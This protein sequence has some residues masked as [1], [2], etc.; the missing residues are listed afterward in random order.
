MRINNNLMAMNTHRQ[1][2]LGNANGAKSMEKL[3]SGFRINRAGDGS[4]SK[5]ANRH[6][7]AGRSVYTVSCLSAVLWPIG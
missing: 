2:G 5:N 4:G 7:Q 1:L 6:L 3:S